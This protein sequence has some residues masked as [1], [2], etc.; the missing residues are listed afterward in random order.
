MPT[1]LIEVEDLH[2]YFYTRD[3]VVKAVNGVSLTLDE[4]SILGVVGESGSGK[5]VTAL[6]ILQLVPF[7]GKILSGSIRYN[8]TEL[9]ALGSEQMRRIRGKEISLIFQD[10]GA[11]LN[12][13][14]PIGRQIEEI[15]LEH[16][17]MSKGQ[18]RSTAAELLTQ[19]G[20]PDAKRMLDRY[21]FQISGGMAQ[22]V[23]MAIGVA[24]E[25]KVL[26]ADEPTSNLDVTL[27]AEML[28]RL[29]RLQ[30]ENHSA[31]MLITHDL[32]IIA[33]MA[34]SVAVMYGGTIVE[35]ADTRTLFARP[36]HP[37]TWGLFQSLPRLD[38]PTKPL[39]PMR[40]LPPQMLDPP[41]QCPYL[42]VCPKAMYQCRTS[43]RPDLVELEPGHKVACYNPITHSE[44]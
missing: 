44:S 13:V 14:I 41:D 28:Q 12:P 3:G 11:A 16:T 30:Q 34:D 35:R 19:M 2:T 7:P 9:L 36:T 24:L 5:T 23:M 15:M 40:G 18:A 25:P 37:F 20:M 31:I 43:P 26:I 21:P 22:R 33:Q 1:P 42:H 38:S 6:S 4:D 27:Q 17:K 8:G 10:A 39:T 32:G 29:R